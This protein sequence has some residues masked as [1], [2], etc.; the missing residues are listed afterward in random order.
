[1]YCDHRC[2]N[3]SRE[4]TIQGWKL[5]KGGNYSRVETIQGQ[6]LF[7]EIRYYAFEN[8]IDFYTALIQSRKLTFKVNIL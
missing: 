6:K 2:G 5:F 4:E 1:M 7:A 3:F 8:C